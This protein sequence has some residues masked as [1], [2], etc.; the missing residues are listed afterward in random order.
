M[1]TFDSKKL[2]S[3]STLGKILT[4]LVPQAPLNYSHVDNLW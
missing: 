3:L 2:A 4:L 1:K